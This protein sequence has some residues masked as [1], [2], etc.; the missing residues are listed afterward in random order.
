MVMVDRLRLQQVLSNLLT[1]A[2][3]YTDQGSVTLRMRTQQEPDG[4]LACEFAVMDTGVG[5][6]KEQIPRI[7]REFGRLN[8][9]VERRE[10]GTGL[11]LA[12]V[13]RI[14]EGM[15]TELHVEAAL[16][17]GSVFGFRLR[18][19]IAGDQATE[20]SALPLS[21]VLILYAEDE[22]VIRRVTAR[23][24][25]DAGAR[26]ISAVNGEDALRLLA[27]M[28]PDLL[29]VDLQ[30]PVLD[31]VGMIRRIEET[32]PEHTFPIFVLTSHISGP[33]AA[34]ARAAGAVTVLTKPVQVAALAAAF[35][36]RRG[37]ASRSDDGT[38]EDLESARGPL[39]DLAT[40]IDATDHTN[41]AYALE[42][43]VDFE[44]SIRTAVTELEAANSDGDVLEVRNLAH[45]SLG[46]CQVMGALSLAQ[47]LRHI[48]N[49]ALAVDAAAIEILSGDCRRIL[50][51]TLKE[52]RS[53]IE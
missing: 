5:L 4:S 22:P 27:T 1:N 26:V 31:G 32:W 38:G 24:L 39:L 6:A 28:S 37:F 42:L 46:L 12:I 40:F 49:K 36:A 50:D 45:R 14:L 10:P 48:E 34:E 3:K 7:L 16:G 44:S 25:E 23:S 2:V 15:G 29:L 53:K 41:K 20:D 35:R 30:L 18:L 43:V 13:Q 19:P 9:E 33:Q 52:M 51:V 11:G 21:G 17:G 47:C 8:R